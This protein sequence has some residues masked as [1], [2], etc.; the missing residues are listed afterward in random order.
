MSTLQ[1]DLPEKVEQFVSAKV[2]G[3]RYESAGEFIVAL[4]TACQERE[5]IENQLL[6]AIESND[7]Q[8]VTPDFWQRL[9]QRVGEKGSPHDQSA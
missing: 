4:V 5:C 2:A 9:R 7:F 6:A 1:I 8:E 3:G